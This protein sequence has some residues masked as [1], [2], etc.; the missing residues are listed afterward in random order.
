MQRYDTII[1]D[2]NNFLDL[3]ENGS[4]QLTSKAIIAGMTDV[5][6][7]MQKIRAEAPRHNEEIVA[8][9]LVRA[10][11]NRAL[12]Y[13]D[14]KKTQLALN[15]FLEVDQ[16][17]PGNKDV[18]ENIKLCTEEIQERARETLL[19]NTPPTDVHTPKAQRIQPNGIDQKPE[20]PQGG[21]VKIGRQDS[22]F[23]K[24]EKQQ[25]PQSPSPH[26]DAGHLSQ[27]GGKTGRGK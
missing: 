21:Y 9:I 26:R 16:L 2:D 3:V 10:Y 27:P 5:I 20:S 22:A 7:D 13:F 23:Y 4:L 15:D 17:N 24:H 8:M 12:C 18:K 14:E 11:W 19:S 1:A 25:R 6:Q